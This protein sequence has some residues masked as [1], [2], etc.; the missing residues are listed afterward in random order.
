M[1]PD[2]GRPEAGTSGRREHRQ[3]GAGVPREHTP[4]GYRGLGPELIHVDAG[5]VPAVAARV[6]RAVAA[7]S[8]DGPPIR[9]AHLRDAIASGGAGMACAEHPAAGI[10][11]PAC[12]TRHTRRH[13]WAVEHRCDVC[14]ALAATMRAL[15]GREDVAVTTRTTTG[16]RSLYAGVLLVVA[17]GTCVPC[18]DAAGLPAIGTVGVER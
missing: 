10:M 3:D 14:G 8:A 2:A 17:V 11:C 16:R 15:V 18:G 9:C 13:S 4:G 12:S 7:V 5:T 1:S 6:R